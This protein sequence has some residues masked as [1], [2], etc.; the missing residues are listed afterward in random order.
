M[1]KNN[2]LYG[3]Y[4][5]IQDALTATD[6]KNGAFGTIIKQRYKGLTVGIIN[7]GNIDEY[8]FK[9]GVSDK[10]L[11]KKNI[12]DITELKLDGNRIEKTTFLFSSDLENS[13]SPLMSKINTQISEN[14]QNDTNLQNRVS[15]AVENSIQNS[16]TITNAINLGIQGNSTITKFNN[17]L[18]G[19][20]IKLDALPTALRELPNNFENGVIK[21][22][23]LPTGLQKFTSNLSNDGKLITL[24]VLPTGIITTE[25][26][27]DND[28]VKG[29]QGKFDSNGKLVNTVLPT[30]LQ[31]FTGKL[32]VDGKINSLDILPTTE[33]TDSILTT[34][35]INSKLPQGI[36]DFTE[37]LTND[38]KLDIKNLVDGTTPITTDTF[39]KKE[40]L[41][42]L[43]TEFINLSTVVITTDN[44]KD[45]DIVKGLQGKFDSEGN[46]VNT[47]LP[48]SVITETNLDSKLP[49]TLVHQ[50]TLDTR[51]ESKANSSD[52]TNLQNIAI[53]TENIKDND[54]VKGLQSK[55]GSDGK[56]V[57]TVLPTGLQKFTSN[58]SNDGKLATLDVLPTGVI[59]NTNINDNLPN[60]V[61]RKDDLFDNGKLKDAYIPTTLATIDALNN[62]SNSVVLQTDDT[63]T[64]LKDIKDNLTILSSIKDEI[65]DENNNVKFATYENIKT[66]LLSDS[67]F[68]DSIASN[69]TEDINN[70]SP[71]T[72]ANNIITNKSAELIGT[73]TSNSNFMST[74]ANNND[75]TNNIIN[76][77]DFGCEILIN[78]VKETLI[79][80]GES[81]LSDT[82]TDRTNAIK[83]FDISG[84]QTALNSRTTAISNYGE[85]EL[86]TAK[87]GKLSAIEDFDISSLDTTLSDRTTA[88]SSYGKTDLESAISDRT[89]AISSYGESE[90]QTARTNKLSEINNFDISSLDTTLSDRTTAISS[91]GKTDLESAISDRT[92]A[93]SSYGESELQTA[94]EDKLNYITQIQITPTEVAEKINTD[95]VA[96]AIDLNNKITEYVE[97]ND[98]SKNSEVQ[99]QITNVTTELNN[100]LANKADSSALTS[101]QKSVGTLNSR[102]LS[103][104]TGFV[105]IENNNI[106]QSNLDLIYNSITD[107]RISSD[108][109]TMKLNPMETGY[110]Y[111][112]LNNYNEI[113]NINDTLKANLD[114]NESYNFVFIDGTNKNVT[115]YYYT[116]NISEIFNKLNFIYNENDGDTYSQIHSSKNIFNVLLD[117][118]QELG[119][120]NY[121]KYLSELCENIKI[122]DDGSR[123][124]C[125]SD[126]KFYD[127]SLKWTEISQ[128]LQIYNK[129]EYYLTIKNKDG[130][131]NDDFIR[132]FLRDNSDYKSFKNSDLIN[133]FINFINSEITCCD[134]Q[135]YQ[136]LIR[137]ITNIKTNDLFKCYTL[138]TFNKNNQIE[139]QDITILRLTI[140][141]LINKF[142]N[143]IDEII[144]SY[145]NYFN[146]NSQEYFEKFSEI[147][148]TYGVD[149]DTYLLAFY[150]TLIKINSSSIYYVTTKT[151]D[152]TLLNMKLSNFLN[153]N[154]YMVNSRWEGYNNSVNTIKYENINNGSVSQY[155]VDDGNHIIELPYKLKKDSEN[156]LINWLNTYIIKCNSYLNSHDENDLIYFG[157]EYDIDVLINSYTYH[158]IPNA[159]QTNAE[160]Y[161]LNYLTSDDVK[162]YIKNLSEEEKVKKIFLA[163][164]EDNGYQYIFE[165]YVLN[166][167]VLMTFQ[168]Y[169]IVQYATSFISQL[170]NTG[171]VTV[172]GKQFNFAKS[173]DVSNLTINSET[174]MEV[175]AQLVNGL[176]EDLTLIAQKV[177]LTDD[178]K[179]KLSV[180][181][182]TGT[183]GKL[184]YDVTS[185]TY[186]SVKIEGNTPVNPR[187]V[188]RL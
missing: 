56:L 161:D 64:S 150:N 147:Y 28:I 46:L 106:S 117:K 34:D 93:I 58:L 182:L 15:E 72:I 42:S 65:I 29:L 48:T 179:A 6:E 20:N 80:Y 175:V 107:A 100:S 146:Q 12:E 83:D 19:E 11:I 144:G 105:N 45:N 22:S 76:N 4:K 140:D 39:A 135:F 158:I 81:E 84:L 102:T 25:N 152:D 187:H 47:A 155:I 98:I 61:A 183:T 154:L 23:V 188:T 32:D 54:I 101:L 114:E 119:L 18:D 178:E 186:K 104:K 85:S 168:E 166:G 62:L 67:N 116:L 31:K 90:L 148:Y 70:I 21:D 151:F 167:E 174:N 131:L 88:I 130:N 33:L 2:K 185:G 92:T 176:I 71:E 122:I 118:L 142:T 43:S 137:N 169:Y 49:N 77:N 127:L 95:A 16:D 59:T 57:N 78:N 97:T 82:L 86:Q 170:V 165:Q 50:D 91:Y 66:G 41:S 173:D 110:Y 74:L 37:K 73:I 172:G 134:S 111:F 181:D 125:V 115:E 180:I 44:I 24:D 128:V 126:T 103:N 27:K 1:L 89:T 164:I 36:K 136:Y 124:Q 160:G 184:T 123:I 35:N 51:L 8:W 94:K 139:C 143:G 163:L 68:N 30:G 14:I 132:D 109:V 149:Y 96:N 112:I 87:E 69:I 9:N 13:E 159:F 153:S 120:N 129:T 113:I 38:G 7:N 55:F 133:N 145:E 79:S 10:D 3:P 156:E 177:S 162:N 40:E 52:L 121:Y 60:S 141:Y 17:L 5:S 138:F 157:S 53:T 108:E 99:T 26:I 63:Y 171:G 75:L